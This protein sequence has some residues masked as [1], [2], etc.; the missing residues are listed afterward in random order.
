MRIEDSWLKI[1]DSAV[2][3][4]CS[5]CA[6]SSSLL[7]S[8]SSILISLADFHPI[9]LA[10]LLVLALSACAGR[11]VRPEAAVKPERR[12][13]SQT[14]RM[15]PPEP[16]LE[17]HS[18]YAD[19]ELEDYRDDGPPQ[20]V[21]ADL[22]AVPDAEPK[23]EPLHAYANR[24]Y[25]VLGKAY[26]PAD[27][28]Q[29]YRQRGLAS[30]YGKKFHGRK[31]STGEIYDMYAMTAAHRTLAIPAYARVTHVESGKAV[32]VRV[33]DRGP[34]HSDRIIDLSYTAA[35]KLGIVSDGTSLVEVQLIDPDLGSQL[36]ARDEKRRIYLQLGAFSARENA[37]KFVA[38]VKSQLA[39]TPNALAVFI[40][41]G[42]YRAAS[43][44]Y[45]TR[46]EAMEAAPALAKLIKA[47]PLV[48]F[49]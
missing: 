12:S 17:P 28:R 41:D 20:E 6:E 5:A 34:F 19:T 27:E 39:K 24:P 25:E 49:R 15:P 10:L 3:G 16:K 47:R 46:K 32:V 11:D 14:V 13:P 31:T 40:K 26:V 44:P 37:D 45:A 22:D 30:W 7:D 35:Y 1:Q 23:S 8:Q 29:P 4:R 2:R 36:T 48:I 33:N 21:P 38:Q 43:G 9:F 18:G 42:L